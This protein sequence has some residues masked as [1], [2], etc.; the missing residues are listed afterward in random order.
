MMDFGKPIT[1]NQ[2]ARELHK[3]G[4]RT[5]SKYGL[6]DLASNHFNRFSTKSAYKLYHHV[7]KGAYKLVGRR[8]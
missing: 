1:I 5:A 3:I 4:V 7:G 2:M 8:A 6:R